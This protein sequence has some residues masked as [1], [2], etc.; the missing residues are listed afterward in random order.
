MSA[1]QFTGTLAPNENQLW[2]TF[3]WPVDQDVAWQVMPTTAR[4]GAPEIEWTVEIERADP[5]S[6]T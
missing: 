3:G 4:P 2:F 1:V 5:N 6:I